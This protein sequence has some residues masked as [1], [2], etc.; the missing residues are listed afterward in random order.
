[1]TRNKLQ[2]ESLSHGENERLTLPAYFLSLEVEN[3]RSFGPKQTLDLSNGKSRPTQWTIILGDN[4]VGKTTLLQCITALLPFPEFIDFDTGEGE[5]KYAAPSALNIPIIEVNWKP[6]RHG[7]ELIHISA[8]FFAGAKLTDTSH[9]SEAGELLLEKNKSGGSSADVIRYSRIGE[10]DCF[11]YGASRRM[12]ETSLSEKAG[13]EPFASLF[14]DD[15]ALLNAEEWLLQADYTAHAA[16]SEAVRKRA[17]RRRDEIKEVLINLLPDVEDIR[18]AQLT[19]KQQKPGVEVKTPYGWVSIKDLSLGYKT[20]IAWMVDFASRMFDR[21][22]DSRNP[23]AEPAVVLVDEIDLHLH[24]KWQRTLMG[25]L[26]ERFPNTQF[27]ATAHSPLVVQAA[28]DANIVLLR[29]VGDH[30]VIE[31]DVKAIHGWRVDQILTSDLF[32][33][34]NARPPQLDALLEE[35]TKLLSKSRLTKKDRARLKKLEEEIGALP[36]GETPADMEA[37]DIIRRA[38]ARLKREGRE[39]SHD[40]G[41]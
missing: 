31:N 7:S 15:V 12:G 6:Y 23:L 33:L 17:E 16:K 37:M 39:T 19:E 41:D 21:Y 5:E 22:P 24:P 18:F 20:L 30:V 10:I 4:G 25:Y 8:R 26:S 9:G 27:I 3:V 40:P 11:G 2:I 35:R 34:E 32:G 29:R 36:T 28:S 14:S 13:D 1:M 38:A